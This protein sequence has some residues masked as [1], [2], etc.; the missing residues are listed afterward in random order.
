MLSNLTPYTYYYK[1]SFQL[2][3]SFLKE[4]QNFA[5]ETAFYTGENGSGADCCT[6]GTFDFFYS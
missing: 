4:S 5:F 1:N 2:K 3:C 6:A